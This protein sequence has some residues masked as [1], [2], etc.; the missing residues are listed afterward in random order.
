MIEWFKDAL[1][2][3]IVFGVTAVG[4]FLLPAYGRTIDCLPF[5]YEPVADLYNKLAKAC[6]S[7]HGGDRLPNGESVRIWV[8][9]HKSDDCG[10]IPRLLVKVRADGLACV[11]WE[12]DE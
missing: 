6:Y 3:A 12:A 9:R 10:R 5:E 8:L 2:L 11:W 7:M 4:L 1:K